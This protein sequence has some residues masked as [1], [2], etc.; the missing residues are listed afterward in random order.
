LDFA[1]AVTAGSYVQ[2]ATGSTALGIG[3][4]VAANTGME[5]LRGLADDMLRAGERV[6]DEL[7]GTRPSAEP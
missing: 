5:Q 3:V 2:G 4:G 6:W 1:V 7:T